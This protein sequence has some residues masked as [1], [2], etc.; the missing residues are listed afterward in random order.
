M[1]PQS[2]CCE[3]N[4]EEGAAK[5]GWFLRNSASLHHTVNLTSDVDGSGVLQLRIQTAKVT[6]C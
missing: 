1:T 4:S 5:G 3:R 6:V 2:E